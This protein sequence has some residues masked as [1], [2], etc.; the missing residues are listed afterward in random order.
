MELF[1]FEA[2]FFVQKT[3]IPDLFIFKE[4]YIIYLT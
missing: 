1:G 2:I 4:N 3:N